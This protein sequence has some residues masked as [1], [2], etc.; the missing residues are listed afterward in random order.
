MKKIYRGISALII[1]VVINVVIFA[2]AEEQKGAFWLSYIFLIIAFLL[3]GFVSVYL[4]DVTNKRILGYPLIAG[5]SVYLVLEIIVA[6]VFM[7]AAYELVVPALLVQVILLAVFV[8]GLLSGQFVNTQIHQK[9]HMRETDLMNFR[10]IL[11]KMKLVQQKVEYSAPYRKTIEQAYDSLAG[12]QVTSSPEVKELETDI[13]SK[14]DQLSSAVDR[15]ENDAI[16]NI[17]GE[18]LNLSQERELRLK[19]KQPF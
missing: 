2:L 10:F 4:S 18:L 8:L 13:L 14:V 7:L 11:E 12:G 9:E 3:F 1:F 17:C 6:L 5:A 19:M 16:R 15:K